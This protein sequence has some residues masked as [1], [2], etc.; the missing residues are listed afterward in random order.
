MPPGLFPLL[1]QAILGSLFTS[2]HNGNILSLTA[3]FIWF[4]D[5]GV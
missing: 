4:F 2:T 3:S 5:G 1:K